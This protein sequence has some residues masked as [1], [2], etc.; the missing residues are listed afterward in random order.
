M[1]A[2]LK[3]G[4]KNTR[5][6]FFFSPTFF[7]QKYRDSAQLVVVVVG[8]LLLLFLLIILLL[9]KF[10]Q[11]ALADGFGWSMSDNKSQVMVFH[12]SL[13]DSKSPRVFR[14]FPSILAD[15]NNAVVVIVSTCLLISKSSSLFSSPLEIVPS[16][17]IIIG[18]TVTFM[19]HSFFL[20]HLQGRYLSLFSLLFN[21]TLW[22]VGSLFYFCW[23]SLSQVVWLYLKISEKFVRVILQDRFRVVHIPDVSMVKF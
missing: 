12:W 3:I 1:K 16:A 9:W 4:Y 22:S 2:H 6:F 17:P 23:L 21:F 10:S 7:Q 14:T 13:S 5:V 11:P 8:H 20:L 19:F 18:M 15:L